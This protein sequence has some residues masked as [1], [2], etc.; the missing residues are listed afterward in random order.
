MGGKNNF[1]YLYMY[2]SPQKIWDSEGSQMIEVYLPFRAKEELRIWASHQDRQFMGRWEEEM[3]GKLRLPSRVNE[4]LCWKVISGNSFLPRIGP[5]P[6]INF[7]Y[8]KVT[9]TLFLE[10]LLGLQFLRIIFIPK[11][12]ILRWHILS[13]S[14]LESKWR[15]G[16]QRAIMSHAWPQPPGMK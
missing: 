6:N 16:Y 12:P 4:I 5:L 13:F 10:L 1:S 11:K 9:C 7:L 3:F 8:K 2:K 14:P 15:D